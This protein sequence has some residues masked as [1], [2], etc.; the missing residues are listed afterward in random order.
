M[1]LSD[2][3]K[4]GLEM[5]NGD[6]LNY[7]SSNM[8][9]DWRFGSANLTNA[10]MGLVPIENS[11]AV[12]KGDMVDTFCPTLW[13]HPNSQNLGF[14]NT[15]V[16][17][18]TSNSNSVGIR[19]GVPG[20]SR[21]GFDKDLDMGWNLVNLPSSISKGGL[22]SQTGAGILPQ[23]LSHFPA[24]SAFIERAA[25]FSCFNGGNFSDMVNH[26]GISESL[27]SPYS[28]AGEVIRGLP[29]FLSG[30]NGLKPLSGAQ[31]QKNESNKAE[32]SKDVSLSV[33]HGATEGSPIRNERENRGVVRPSDEAKQAVGASSNDSDEAEFSGG[34]GQEE[35]SMLANAGGEPSSAKELGSK[36]RKRSGQDTVLDQVK[37]S[38]KLP[39]EAAKD[40]TEIKQKGDQN[41]TPTTTKPTGKH[42]KDSSQASDAPEEDYIHVRA[43][44]GQAT[45]S[46]SLAERVR[47]EKISE[48]MKFLQDLVP[49]CSKVT[50]KA[51]MLDEIINYVQSLQQQVEFLSMKLAAVNP[52]LDFNIEGLLAKDVPQSRGAISSTMGFSSDMGMAHHLLHPSHQGLIQA[53]IPGM[54]NPSDTL[55]RTINSHFTTMNGSY[56]EPTAQLPNMWD[57]ELHTVVQMNYGASAPFNS[58]ELNVSMP[59]GHMKVEP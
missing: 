31:P 55:R 36:K 28:R 9:S 10:S 25:R 23:S 8:S 26:F 42:G 12:C 56:K 2:K 5:S 53:G 7:H 18:S 4:F 29:E 38:P 51:V 52:R 46:H 41:P 34:G 48:R 35:P 50:G 1:D 17:A 6:P 39:G 30:N 14:C 44:R 47:R 11:M 58:Q 32:F 24:D 45:N 16:Q 40:S 15:N 20:V 57:N 19:K 3:D 21:T 49:G 59:Q 27:S 43:R 13:D 22:F 33:E 54:G 37:G